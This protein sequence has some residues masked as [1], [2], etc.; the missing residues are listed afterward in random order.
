MHPLSTVITLITQT[1]VASLELGW[2]P[3]SSHRPIRTPLRTFV[4]E[5]IILHLTLFASAGT[6]LGMGS[7]C[8]CSRAPTTYGLHQFS[9]ISFQVNFFVKVTISGTGS[10]DSS[11]WEGPKTMQFVPKA[12]WLQSLGSIVSSLSGLRGA[13]PLLLKISELIQLNFALKVLLP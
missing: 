10:W 4:E 11:G 6:L 9:G 5:R 3:I 13:K 1:V 12:F 7:L 8:T 2:K